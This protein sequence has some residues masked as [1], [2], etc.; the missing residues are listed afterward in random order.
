MGTDTD[1]RATE[2]TTMAEQE[3]EIGILRAESP[4]QI[5]Q[6]RCQDHHP[7]MVMWHLLRPKKQNRC[8]WRSC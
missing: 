6:P 2:F 5:S 1:V 7:Q 3:A 8:L 4:A